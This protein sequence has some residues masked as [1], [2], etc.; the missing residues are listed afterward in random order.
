MGFPFECRAQR[1]GTSPGY[2]YSCIHTDLKTTHAPSTV[3][4]YAV[5]AAVS[6]ATGVT[7][8]H[9]SCAIS[10]TNRRAEGRGRQSYTGAGKVEGQAR[11]AGIRVVYSK[12]GTRRI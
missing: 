8:V 9:F 10:V 5:H 3:R 7:G 6:S 2:L 4:L 12:V 1:L 11:S